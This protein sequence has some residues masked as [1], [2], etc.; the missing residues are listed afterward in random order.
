MGIFGILLYFLIAPESPRY[1]FMNK[2]SKEAID[3]L[4]YIAWFNFSRLRIPE[5]A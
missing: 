5:D 3:V 1:L 4:N 2:K